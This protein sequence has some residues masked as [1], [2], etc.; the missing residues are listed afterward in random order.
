MS[1]IPSNA[2]AEPETHGI[3]TRVQ[4][5][6]FSASLL[7]IF[8][9]QIASGTVALVTEVLYARLL[10]PDARGMIGLALMSIA[11]GTL[12]GGLGGEGSIVYW[13]SRFKTGQSSWLS[14]IFFSGGVG[15]LAAGAFWWWIFWRFHPAFLRGVSTAS[16]HV[17]FASI[18]AAVLFSYAMALA[19]G[20]EQFRLRSVCAF[21]RQA[22][23]VSSFLILILIAGRS[24]EAALWGNC[25]G[26]LIGSF[27]ALALM[28][29]S[30][31]RFIRVPG[32]GEHLKPTMAYG[33]RGQVGNLAAFFS[34]RLD[35]FIVNFFLGPAQLG[36]YA[37]G[38]AVSEGL[39]Q[40]PN[41]VSSAVFPRTGRTV[42]HDATQFNCFLMRQVFLITSLCA[43][44]VA[45][46]SPIVIPLLFG[47]RF[48]P[49]VA[50]IWWI[51]PGTVAL[52]LA[53]VACSD[54]AGRGKNGYS[55]ISAFICFGATALLD[56]LLIPRMGI[57][58]ASLASSISYTVD[59]VI[60]LS[61]VC[62][63]LR[64]GWKS[65]LVPARG[66]FEAYRLLWLRFR[67]LLTA[68]LSRRAGNEVALSS[69]E[70][71]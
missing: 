35:V 71:G 18:P 63:E 24:V 30:V 15:C 28:W 62:Y 34:Y 4:N 54:L 68:Y 60:I 2:I 47:G 57:L 67:R 49:S 3:S 59:A 14:A 10:G 13:A 38:V 6:A 7:A 22:I 8:T 66:D 51:L 29:R 23:G 58:G 64:I 33:V 69:Q 12:V 46:A 70:G 39:W 1:T 11:F 41:A 17:V 26:L 52:S 40:V 5:P 42:H 9:G 50:V 21:L 61:A 65:L 56:W 45:V 55:S 37:V 36:L 19:T 20:T 43:A 44:A 48:R 32:I 25:A 53:K 31:Q 16:A 27:A